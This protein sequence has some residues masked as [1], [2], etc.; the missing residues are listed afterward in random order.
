MTLRVLYQTMRADFLER[1][2]SYQFLIVL[3]LM[4]AVVYLFVPTPGA[5]YVTIDLEGYRGIYNSA[6][7]GGS[8]AMLVA[9]YLGLLAFYAVKGSVN[10]DRETG[11]GQIIASTPLK[12]PLYMLAKWLSNMGVLTA[13]TIVIVIASGALQLVRGEDRSIEILTLIAPF[14]IIVLPTMAVIAAIA[15][16][17]ESVMFLRGGL[18]NV[19]F[20]FAWIIVG[21]PLALNGSFVLANMEDGLRAAVPSYDG[22]TSCCLILESNAMDVL[23]R[24]LAAQDTFVWGGMEWSTANISLHVAMIGAALLVVLL[25]AWRFDRFSQAGGATG[26]LELLIE[27]ARRSVPLPWVNRDPALTSLD[28]LAETN[29]GASSDRPTKLTLLGAGSKGVQFPRMLVAELR[30]AIKGLPWWW[31]TV[32]AGL[33]AAS[34]FLELQHVHRWLLPVAWLWPVLIWSGM[35]VRETEHHT[36]LLVFSAPHSLLRQLPAV[37]LVG[38]VVAFLTGSGVLARLAIAGDG[39]AM[40]TWTVGA[41]FVPSLALALGTWSGNGKPFQI[42]Y[43]M[44]WFVGPMQGVKRLDFMALGGVEA[45][46]GSTLVFMAATC[47]LLAVGLAGRARQLRT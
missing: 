13:M 32:A 14:V 11:V 27:R 42:V 6:W 45:V 43:L 24:E 7:I 29:D 5:D 38:F 34:F 31:Y 21:F 22:G 8:V 44:L 25:A 46:T 2:R 41:L 10:R 36:D 20:F 17:F 15:L 19:V 26:R 3:G 33:V 30:L 12:K 47:M 35:G 1:V 23:G 28:G 39:Y 9:G 18:G 37:W 16:L 4:V 40:M